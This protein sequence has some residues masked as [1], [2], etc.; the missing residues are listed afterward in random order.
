MASTVDSPLPTPTRMRR[1]LV[2]AGLVYFALLV[3]AIWL[4]NALADSRARGQGQRL[5]QSAASSRAS[6]LVSELQK[7]RLLPIVLG[8][9][10]LVHDTLAAPRGANVRALDV[11]LE[12]LAHAIGSAAV[13]LLDA[14]GRAIA[15]SNWRLPT[16]FVGQ[17]YSFRPYFTQAKAHGTAE[18]FGLG[19]VSHQPGL[20]LSRRVGSGGDQ[21]VIVVKFGFNAVEAGW[22]AQPDIVYVA[23]ADGVVLVT[24]RPEWRYGATQPLAPRE[25]AAIRRA[26]Q[27]DA[28][29]PFR[30][31]LRPVSPGLV[32][33][34]GDGGGDLR[35]AAATMSV[36]VE[37]W[38]LTD[39]QPLAPLRSAYL[40]TARLAIAAFAVGLLL[41]LVLWVRARE[42]ADLAAATRLELERRVLERTEA[43]EAA[44]ARFR[45]ARE[46]LAHANR[47]GSI[48]QITAAVAHEINQ[49][50]GAIRAFA[51]NAGEFL[52]RGDG[53]S[54]ARN[55]AQ[56]VRLTERIGRI[57]AELRAYARRG[58][59]TV[60]PVALDTAM[61]GALM[62]IGHGLRQ[63]DVTVE[64][65][66]DT[67]LRVLADRVRLEQVLV[68]LIQN[69]I[70]ATAGVANPAITLI[71][72]N[73][74]DTV[75]IAIADNGPGVDARVA[76]TLFAAFATTKPD[77]L[78]LGLGI[79]RD[80]AREFGGDLELGDSAQGACF[81][82]T[83]RPA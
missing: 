47:L 5:A 44:Q 45:A 20:F 76:D 63:H 59:G 55:L 28:I 60:K 25:I 67:G 83:L 17:D 32:A 16:S 70:E 36:P 23:D 54:G 64:R 78:G 6:L 4:G 48:G 61:D 72:T 19:T 38:T 2:G 57:T 22:G 73:H 1:R 11:K 7:Y 27:F 30:L 82:L 52:R 43:L 66:G 3:L 41:L 9:L 75:R 34:A 77:G 35:Y 31:P 46:E 50:V 74:A 56:I 21:G 10:P 68:N 13:Y 29:A 12:G 51:D 37:G 80:I 26:R 65:E 69:A 15:A 49:P 40:G 62:L 33:V 81:L 24:N 71:F 8:D 14:H 79:A 58:S 53:A 39:L 18:F 42:R